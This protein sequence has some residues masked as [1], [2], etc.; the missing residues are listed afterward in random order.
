MRESVLARAI[1]VLPRADRRRIL[2]VIV[3]QILLGALDLLGVALIGVLG[4]LAVNGVQSRP[5]GDRVGQI[6]SFFGV[7]DENFQM[8]AAVLGLAATLVLVTRTLCSIYFLRKILFFLSRRGAHIS[9]TLVGKLLSQSILTIQTRTTQEILY[10]VTIGVG[11]ITLGVLGTIVSLISDVALLSIMAVGLFIVDPILAFST[12]ILFSSIAFIMYWLTQRRA[13]KLGEIS[14]QFSIESNEKIMEVLSSYREAVVKNRRNFYA[15]EIGNI[16]IKLANSA[17][18]AAFLPNVSKYVIESTIVI[19]ALLIS[20]IQFNLTDAAH[21]VATLAVF[22]AAGSRIA[23]AVLRVQQSALGVRGSLGAAIPTLDLID[24][25]RNSTDLET[26][27]DEVQTD[28]SG[29]SPNI[30]LDHVNFSYP[31]ENKLAI[32]DLCLEIPAGKSVAIVGS[33]GAGKTTLVDLILGVLNPNSGEILIS[34]VNP[35]KAISNWPGSISYVPQ[36]VMIS[37]GTIS[38]NVGLGYPK[39]SVTKDLVNAAVRI[40]SLN[41]YILKQQNGVDTYIGE[42]GVRMSG[43]ER[44]RLGI[45]RAMFTQPSLLVLDEAT[46]S[47][48]GETEANVADAIQELN[49]KIT[50]LIIAHRLSTIV[51]SD[52]VIYLDKGKLLAQ[53][54]FNEVRKKVVDFDNQAKLMGL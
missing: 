32:N 29:F 52:I 26:T 50:V 19:S 5:A 20:A 15:R 11:S 27:T 47:L 39:K 28:H 53:G 48:D 36:D 35:K 4:A 8:Q 2:A 13:H 1:L 41:D 49:G 43:G 17:A 10:S 44:Q 46:S 37:N 38:E 25:L 23:P 14:A 54:S 9:A 12:F 51:N 24:S 3:I 31:G 7:A 18:E 6:L 40:A 34:G 22:L 21:A 45:A 42:R 16:R 30:C 33:S